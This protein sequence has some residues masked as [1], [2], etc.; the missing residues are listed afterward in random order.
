[1]VVWNCRG[2][3]RFPKI[4]DFAELANVSPFAV[5]DSTDGLVGN[6]VY[7]IFEARN[8]DIW[9]SSFGPPN[10]GI[11]HWN[12]ASNTFHQLKNK[13][14]A[15]V[16]AY[17]FAEDNFGN[18]WFGLSNGSLLRLKNGVLQKLDNIENMPETIVYDMLFD[19]RKNLWLA[20]GAGAFLVENISSDKPIFTPLTMADGLATNDI[21]A[22]TDDLE[23]RI[24]FATSQGIQRYNPET[25]RIELFTTADGIANSEL[26]TAIRSKDGNLWFGTIRGLTKFNP[27]E[28]KDIKKAAPIFIRSIQ[29]GGKPYPISELGAEDISGIEILPNQNHLEIEVLGLSLH[30][31]DILKYQ[32]RLGENDEWSE[33]TAQRKFTLVNL[34]PGTYQFEARVMNSRGMISENTSTV[35]F[36]ALAPFY[37]RWWFLL[38][39]A[40]LLCGLAYLFYRSRVKRFLELEK[41]RR[42]IATDLHDDIGSSLSQISLI[43]EVLAI[44]GNGNNDDRESLETIAKTSREAVGSMSEMVWAINP[45]RDNLPDTIN[46]MRRFTTET[47]TAANIRFTFQTSDFDKSTKIEVDVR[48]HIY[49][50]YKEIINNV[51]KHSGASEVSV[52]LTKSGSSFILNATDNGSGFTENESYVGNGLTNM[53][54]RAEKIG[55]VLEIVSEKGKGTSI[56]LRIPIE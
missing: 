9:F 18:I 51:V 47:L 48:R 46:R 32:Y 8:G 2:V 36:T 27:K 49:L 21:I 35:S 50:I 25:K 45:K 28:L 53:R 15:I 23:G 5:Y 14:F 34:K 3:V 4:K 1:M 30:S 6:S 52:K 16:S 37:L 55:A 33:P 38:S 22:I 20:T 24:Y 10:A 13:D 39:I 40:F 31:G 43:S 26:R 11:T 17:S 42:S 56:T 29:I 12:R 19:L 54:S 41:V 7:R 44:K